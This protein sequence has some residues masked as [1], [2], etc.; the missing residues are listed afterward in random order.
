[1][2]LKPQPNVFPEGFLWDAFDRKFYFLLF[3]LK[4]PVTQ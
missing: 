3:S 4:N 2:A 1:M